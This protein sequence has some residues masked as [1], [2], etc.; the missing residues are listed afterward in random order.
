MGMEF[1][2][3][4]TN[5]AKVQAV[6]DT[7]AIH[8][9]EAII[10]YMETDSGVS[11]QPFG[12]EETLDGAINRALNVRSLHKN[13]IGIGLEGGVRLINEKMYICNWGALV[14]T[15]GKRYTAGGAQIPLPDEIALEIQRGKELGPV[16]DAYFQALGLHQREGA[17]GMFTA[18][19]V[20]RID[21][22]QHIIALL[23]GQ[24]KYDLNHKG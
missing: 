14:F 5:N 23:I 12:D 19:I 20:T 15:D 6:K 2:V 13:A 11:N 17:M 9:P 7:V 1:I 4:S 16:I 21:L 24:L 10:E 3:G 8:F 22:F 18:G